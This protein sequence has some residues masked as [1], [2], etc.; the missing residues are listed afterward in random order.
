MRDLAPAK[1][2]TTLNSN[3]WVSSMLATARAS[4]SLSAT[5]SAREEGPVAT[6]GISTSLVVKLAAD[7]RD[8]EVV[9]V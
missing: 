8:V 3:P 4:R 6:E 9:K 5:I 1:L 7:E 2:S